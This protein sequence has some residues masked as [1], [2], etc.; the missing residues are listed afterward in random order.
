MSPHSLVC[1]SL[2]HSRWPFNFAS[3]RRIWISNFACNN[4]MN[5]R[6]IGKHREERKKEREREAE[7]TG[8]TVRGL[9]KALEC[10]K[11]AKLFQIDDFYPFY[12]FL[13]LSIPFSL[14]SLWSQYIE[15]PEVT[16]YRNPQ[17]PPVKS[18]FSDVDSKSTFENQNI[19]EHFKAGA[20]QSS[21]KQ[22]YLHTAYSWHVFR[23]HKKGEWCVA[24]SNQ[25]KA[26]ECPL[27][28]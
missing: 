27:G 25:A 28:N 26:F 19:C 3:N 8:R 14:L 24:F 17:T 10:R 13:S 18:H 4:F 22:E 9:T 12:P 21:M 20:R 16:R 11:G 23:I 7:Q 2:T 1:S 6:V 15:H 5:M